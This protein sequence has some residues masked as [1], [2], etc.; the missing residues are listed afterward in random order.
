M[1]RRLCGQV[2]RGHTSV[3]PNHGFGLELGLGKLVLHAEL[4]QLALGVLLL[5]MLPL[6]FGDVQRCHSSFRCAEAG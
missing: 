1:Q 6:R 5:Q 4:E 2:D 3:T